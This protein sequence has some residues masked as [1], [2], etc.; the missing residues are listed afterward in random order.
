M[1]FVRY[2]N[3]LFLLIRLHQQLVR[4]AD[5]LLLQL[6]HDCVGQ[7]V[8][9]PHRASPQEPAPQKAEIHSETKTVVREQLRQSP[10]RWSG[11][12][13]WRQRR[14]GG[15]WGVRPQHVGLKHVQGPKLLEPPLWG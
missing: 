5:G 4:Q 6:R 9:V 8:N 12:G 11:R 13:G 3:I 1:G 14:R 7:P 15:Q 10:R 2:F